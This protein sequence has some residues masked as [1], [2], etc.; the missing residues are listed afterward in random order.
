[1]LFRQRIISV[2]K[3]TKAILEQ[4]QTAF[5]QIYGIASDIKQEDKEGFASSMVVKFFEQFTNLTLSQQVVLPEE[6]I[7][8]QD[9][10]SVCSDAYMEFI[11][12]HLGRP[13]NDNDVL[14][15]P[16]PVL[17]EL[18]LRTMAYGLTEADDPMRTEALRMLA[19]LEGIARQVSPKE[20]RDK[21]R[22]FDRHDYYLKSMQAYRDNIDQIDLVHK[23]RDRWSKSLDSHMLQLRRQL[24]VLLHRFSYTYRLFG[25]NDLSSSDLDPSYILT[26]LNKCEQD[27]LSKT[28]TRQRSLLMPQTSDSTVVLRQ[29]LALSVTTV[30]TTLNETLVPEQQQWIIT[31][32]Q[33]QKPE[34][35]EEIKK[36]Y[37]FLCR[38]QAD[39]NKL[40]GFRHM[41]QLSGW[42]F[43]VTGVTDPSEI[44]TLLTKRVEACQKALKMEPL[45]TLLPEADRNLLL[46]KQEA[47]SRVQLFQQAPLQL[48]D[49]QTLCQ[50]WRTQMMNCL[51][52]LTHTDAS[53]P[54]IP[55]INQ[56][57]LLALTQTLMPLLSVGQQAERDV[58][59][60]KRVQQAVGKA[61]PPA[62]A[63]E[64]TADKKQE[65][66]TVSPAARSAESRGKGVEASATAVNKEMDEKVC[67]QDQERLQTLQEELASAKTALTKWD[68]KIATKIETAPDDE[69]P[70]Q[71][72]E[73]RVRLAEQITEYGQEIDRIY[74]RA[75]SPQP[76]PMPSPAPHT[77]SDIAVIDK[78]VGDDATRVAPSS[79]LGARPDAVVVPPAH[80]QAQPSATPYTTAPAEVGMSGEAL[81]M[82]K[83]SPSSPPALGHSP[84]PGSV[85]VV[86]VRPTDLSGLRGKHGGLSRTHQSYDEHVLGLIEGGD[87]SELNSL[88]KNPRPIYKMIGHRLSEEIPKFLKVFKR[89]RSA[90]EENLLK[91]TAFNRVL[92]VLLSQLNKQESPIDIT[93]QAGVERYYLQGAKKPEAIESETAVDILVTELRETLAYQRGNLL[94][95]MIDECHLFTLSLLEGKVHTDNAELMTIV[96][97]FRA[98]HPH[99]TEKAVELLTKQAGVLFGTIWVTLRAAKSTVEE[100]RVV[101]ESLC[102]EHAQQLDMWYDRLLTGEDSQ[103]T[104]LVE[105]ANELTR[106]L[107][108]SSHF[109]EPSFGLSKADGAPRP[110]SPLLE[111]TIIDKDSRVGNLL[112]VALTESHYKP[113]VLE[114]DRQATQLAVIQRARPEDCFVRNSEGQSGFALGFGS[115]RGK[116]REAMVNKVLPFFTNFYKDKRPKGRVINY[117]VQYANPTDPRFVPA[118]LDD[119]ARVLDT[120]YEKYLKERLEYTWWQT[121]IYPSAQHVDKRRNEFIKLTQSFAEVIQL[122]QEEG[123]ATMRSIFKAI[124]HIS[125][126]APRGL[127]RNSK[128]HDAVTLATTRLSYLLN[129][130][131]KQFLRQLVQ[132]NTPQISPEQ[133]NKILRKEVEE[134]TKQQEA[135]RQGR[136]AAEKATAEAERQTADLRA[137]LIAKGF[138][139]EE[140]MTIGVSAS[141]EEADAGLAASPSASRAGEIGREADGQ[142]AGAVGFFAAPALAV[143][144][145]ET[146]VAPDL[147]PKGSGI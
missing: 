59:N 89:Y 119:L 10:A 108:E 9:D 136:E 142:A 48:P 41:L 39:R 130:N 64:P 12:T 104:N 95:A 37:Q 87:H 18:F 120:Y 121:L 34:L 35:A 126:T 13:P 100:Q 33:Q 146:G 31:H 61:L 54:D 129:V 114:S 63:K 127:L 22:F 139:P 132:D 73:S 65:N 102:R 125:D 97:E 7:A 46:S 141:A 99:D 5:E 75:R 134:K 25:L 43:I 105:K 28:E 49:M 72:L 6:E 86:A 133:E 20:I 106:H 112:H 82:K 47:S 128:L 44:H 67:S 115:S 123:Y 84:N 94:A 45:D 71:W 101:L 42:L 58:S 76:S 60:L 2:N 14:S 147:S 140:V 78:G 66:L 30:D 1:M 96:N 116:V 81:E 109:A 144:P 91:E 26:T 24:A 110:H 53:R 55:F 29:S 90:I 83:P 52:Q 36:R 32:I 11:N 4:Y 40:T 38:L 74:Q 77:G 23:W 3:Q 131:P 56:Q 15:Q 98:W 57:R 79:T 103:L 27:I 70:P 68:N 16:L 17:R 113:D 69:V 50:I 80:Q 51:N 124:Y 145:D 122:V 111:M 137:F 118:F 107:Y 138:N 117:M 8:M 85:A 135:E 21:S 143:V 93:K 92:N 88:L 62:E 19:N